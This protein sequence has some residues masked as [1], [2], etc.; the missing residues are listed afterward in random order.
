MTDV[1]AELAA[2]GGLATQAELAAH[3]NVSDERVRQ[4]VREKN[5]PQPLLTIGGRRLWVV[6]EVDAYRYRDRPSHLQRPE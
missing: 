6:K 3:W 2:L 5:A 1:R 4:I